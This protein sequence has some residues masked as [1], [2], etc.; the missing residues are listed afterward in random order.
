MLGGKKNKVVAVEFS[1]ISIVE[2][3]GEFDFDGSHRTVGTCRRWRAGRP[4]WA[5][6]VLPPSRH[7]EPLLARPVRPFEHS[8]PAGRCLQNRACPSELT[9]LMNEMIV[10]AQCSERRWCVPGAPGKAP[11]GGGIM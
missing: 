11:R 1:D 7:Q 5:S 10:R 8:R 6:P 2:K 4:P 3:D 9:T